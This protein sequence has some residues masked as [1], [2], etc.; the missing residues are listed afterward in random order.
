MREIKHLFI[1]VSFAIAVLLIV[2]VAVQIEISD[3]QFAFSQPEDEQAQE[4]M[5][6]S[7][8]SIA[9]YFAVKEKRPH[10]A[11]Q[12]DEL[13]MVQSLGE[14]FFYRPSGEAF[15]SDGEKLTYSANRGQYFEASGELH[16]LEDAQLKLEDSHLKADRISYRFN[17]NEVEATGRVSSFHQNRETHDLIE[18]VSD[19]MFARPDQQESRFVGHVSGKI[20]RQR[21]FELPVYFAADEIQ[22]NFEKQHINLVQ[23]VEI[24]RGNVNVR[25]TF[26]EIFLENYNRNL[27]YFTL[28]DDV[29][30]EEDIVLR[31]EAFKRRAFAQRLEAIVAQEILELTGYP[32]VYQRDDVIKGNRVVLRENND[33]IEVDD[34]Q[35]R[36]RIR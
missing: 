26:G 7:F 29:V 24:K 4:L 11:V 13:M 10:F 14:F 17:A 8:F 5:D 31:D 3:S 27:K 30:L 20:R 1:I 36:F 15:N 19:W 9:K 25:S 12:A 28:Y 21:A 6:R 16:L 18:V 22:M 2:V 33:V 34:A 32:K 35:S 23:N